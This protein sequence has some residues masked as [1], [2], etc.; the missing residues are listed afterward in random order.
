MNTELI[1]SVSN[2]L[3]VVRQFCLNRNIKVA[4]AESVSAGIIQALLSTMKEAGLF[5]TGGITTYCCEMKAK[6]LD[7]PLQ[8]C[9]D[10]NGVDP[11]ITNSMAKNICSLFD[12][13]LGIALT[14]YASPIPEEDIYEKIAYGSIYF[15]GNLIC[16]EKFSSDK[17]EQINVQEDFAKQLIQACSKCL[18]EYSALENK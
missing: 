3:E 11:D 6:L 18:T 14:G 4:V 15:Q 17:Q 7:I 16:S 10:T 2:D 12:A 13:G 5:Y 8:K 1:D 9:K